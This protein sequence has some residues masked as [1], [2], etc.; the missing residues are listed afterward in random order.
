MQQRQIFP[1]FKVCGLS[2]YI[3]SSSWKQ[4]TSPVKSSP[5]QCCTLSLRCGALHF[6][7]IT[8]HCMTV[9]CIKQDISRI[10]HLPHTRHIRYTPYV[11]LGWTTLYH[12]ASYFLSSFC[13]LWRPICDL[14]DKRSGYTLDCAH[15]RYP[16]LNW[17]VWTLCGWQICNLAARS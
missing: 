14:L 13:R 8:L 3:T 6:S 2:R 17:D 16:R 5:A 4:G 7:C 9:Q 1:A 15:G 11:A 10:L 12:V